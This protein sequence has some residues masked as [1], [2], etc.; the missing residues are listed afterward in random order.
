MRIRI[1]PLAIAAVL[2]A[3]WTVRAAPEPGQ[4]AT[5]QAP[6][7][8]R[9]FFQSRWTYQPRW[10]PD[11]RYLAYLQDDWTRQHLYVAEPGGGRPRALFEADRFIGDPRT[12]SAGEPPVWSPDSK[13]LLYVVQGDLWLASVPDGRVT[14]LTATEERESGATFLPG[15]RTLGYFRGGA[16]H[17][18][19]RDSGAL[20]QIAAPAGRGFGGLVPSPEGTRAAVSVGRS[21]AFTAVPP[22]VGPLLVFPMSQPEPPDVGVVDLA[23]GRLTLVAVSPQSEAPLAWAPDGHRLLVERVSDD[24]K[25]RNVLL[26]DVASGAAETV[27]SER[28][29]KYLPLTRGFARFDESG[30]SILYMS[31]ATGWN[32]LYRKELASGQ[33][34]PLTSGAWEVREAA[35]GSDGWVYY[36]SSETGPAEPAVFRVPAAGGD[37]E[38]VTSARG[39][40]AD[41][42][43]SPAGGRVVY[44]RS[45]PR[46]VPELWVQPLDAT[47][48]PVRVSDS[49][50]PASAREGW[51]DPQLVTYA[52]H[53]GLEVKAQL[54]VPR[55]EPGRR[56]PAIVH[57]HQAASYQDVYNGPGPQ[58]DNVAWYAWHQR[59]AQLGYVVLN[60][61]YRG[62]TG[63]GR[64]YRVANYQDLG[65]GD[66]LDAVSGVEYL[67]SLGFV[68]TNRVGVYG[69]SYGGHLVLSLLTKNPGLFRAGIDI[70]GVADMRMVY[71]TAGRAAVVA[72]LSTPERRPDLYD[73]S[74]ALM[75]LDQLRDPLMVLHGTD[76]P[77]V[78]V[79]QSLRLVDELLRRGRRFEFEIY[80]GELHFFSRAASWVDAFAKME[81]FFDAEVRDA[82]GAPSGSGPT[83]GHQ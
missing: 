80:P 37:P 74:S 56:Y 19:D 79:L 77:N 54:F 73:R 40:H 58:K 81:R 63:Y 82:G 65:G 36:V 29:E 68:D 46:H 49:N 78:S 11:G 14:Q 66:R 23:T 38:R 83:G 75:H 15:G 76:D 4:F 20:R 31:E 64:D 52:G 3:G 28:D 22:Y 7:S 33:I 47:A 27:L 71:D 61:D 51:Q 30:R 55:R 60:V 69:M 8:M 24:Y 72:R 21:Q 35:P 42:Q 45:D 43:V 9:D 17:L 6:M 26:V 41:L 70:S 10:S 25:E 62:S 44:L 32:H 53:D 67:N 59:L 5:G 57:T 48:S 16:L 18:L 13:E 39:V 1:A 50:P 2:A 12:S 34:T